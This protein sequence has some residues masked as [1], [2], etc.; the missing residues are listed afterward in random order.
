MPSLGRHVI[1]D[2][3]GLPPAVLRDMESVME[4]L[5]SALHAE[6]FTVLR[7]VEHRFPGPGA[8]FTGMFLLSESHAAV[9]T[10]PE[11]GYL[12]LDV[13]G[14][15]PGDARSVVNAVVAALEPEDVEL[16]ALERAARDTASRP[17]ESA[18]QPIV[19]VPG[20]SQSRRSPETP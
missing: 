2:L 11:H 8:G 15:G 10:Y 6:G 12:A 19:A 13:F 7:R 20:C 4:V 1:A 9:H 16:R 18:R 3:S 5:A 14:C 17:P